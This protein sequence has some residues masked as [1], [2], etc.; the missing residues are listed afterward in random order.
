[1]S[2]VI[3]RFPLKLIGET[4]IEAPEYTRVLSVTLHSSGVP[5]L[6]LMTDPDAKKTLKIVV[7]GMLTGEYLEVGE[8]V[9]TFVNTIT[10][11]NGFVAHY[12]FQIE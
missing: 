5:N 4:I 6:Y 12:F 11:P 3:H 1:M 10:L 8:V 7:R 9:G 2:K